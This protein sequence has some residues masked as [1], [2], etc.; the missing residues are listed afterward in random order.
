[1][2]KKPAPAQ[3]EK[4]KVGK[5][6][7]IGNLFLPALKMMW[8]KGFTDV[9][10][11]QA[12]DITEQTL[13]NYKKQYPEIFEKEKDWK[14]EADAAVERSLFERAKGFSAKETKVF[15][16][17][18][19]IITEDVTTNYPPDTTACIFWLKN[20]KKDEWRDRA[21]LDHGSSDGS[22]TPQI[23]FYLPDNGRGGE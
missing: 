8:K 15:V 21:E 17:K 6:T 13:Y 23:S 2:N 22:M 16:Y 3:K 19:D 7:K 18:G 4:K 11:A 20:R 12:F 9:E 14:A 1:M 10:I 5:P